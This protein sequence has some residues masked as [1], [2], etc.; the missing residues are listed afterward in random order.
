MT[1]THRPRSQ[2]SPPIE[3]PITSIIRR[4][5][6]HGREAD[7]DEWARG[8]AA[9]CRKFSGYTGIKLIYPE[10]QGGDYVTIISFKSYDNYV[11]W[12]NSPERA[13]WLQRAR[14][15]M[16]GE[17]VR[18]YIHGFDYWL[19]N[20]CKKG[21]SWPPDYRMVLI[22]YVAIWPLVFFVSPAILPH[23][24]DHPLLASLVSTAVITLLMGY[25]SLP[26]MTR[27][28]RRWILKT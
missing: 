23:L 8:I 10:K 5:V 7:Y 24:P 11:A 20:N 26:L 12:E 3:V 17:D 1:S 14:E 25:V 2:Q 18:E 27:L 4:K 22:A 16:E 9:A 28:A 13:T 6:R 19:E 21:R 15:I